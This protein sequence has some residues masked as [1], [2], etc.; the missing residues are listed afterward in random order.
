MQKDFIHTF[1]LP[2]LSI[3]V[4]LLFLS[5]FINTSILSTGFLCPNPWIFVQ[6]FFRV[7][8]NVMRHGL[9]SICWPSSNWRFWHSTNTDCLLF[10]LLDHILPF[11]FH[12]Q[13]VMVIVPLFQSF[14]FS[15]T[16]AQLQLSWSGISPLPWCIL[17]K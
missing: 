2:K 11:I 8:Y 9:F 4:S 17:V 15:A 1:S 7:F 13:R 16:P 10:F 12:C 5:P 3:M 14:H 6:V